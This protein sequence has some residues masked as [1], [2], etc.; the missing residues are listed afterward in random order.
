MI[1]TNIYQHIDK[2]SK[3]YFR[4]WANCILVKGYHKGVVFDLQRNRRIEVSKYFCDYYDS[5]KDTDISTIASDETFESKEGYFKMLDYFIKNDFGILTDD[6]E[7][8]PDLS[9]EY[10]SPYLVTNAILETDSNNNQDLMFEIVDILSK[11]QV[12]AVQINDHGQMTLAQLK[13]LGE[14]TS[15]S[16]I[17]C[18][19]I[20]TFF[21]QIDTKD[22]TEFLLMNSRFRYIVFMNSP[23][24]NSIKN[25]ELG[26]A[27]LEYK[28][29]TLDF[30]D[31]GNVCKDLFVYDSEHF[32]EAH[33]YN[34]CLNRKVYISQNGLMRNCPLMNRIF[35]NIRQLSIKEIVNSPGFQDLWHVRKDEIDVCKD[36]EYRFVC[37]DCRHYIKEKENIHSQPSKCKYN[38]Y[39]GKWEGESGYVPV[40]ECGRYSQNTGFVPDKEKIDELNERIENAQ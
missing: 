22:L 1:F 16:Q 36:C 23:E 17:E 29:N 24:N 11:G 12:Q 15:N 33:T 13:R 18:I 31:C 40:E 21:S 14:I 10:D 20:Y 9:M 3:L 2:H 35:G 37:T 30:N 32:F 38:P 27:H 8:L 26:L 28:T 6:I 4:F 25:E 39:I 34:T 19:H 7:A 5:Y